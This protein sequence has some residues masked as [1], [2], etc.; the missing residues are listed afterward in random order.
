M[1][2][3]KKL[4]ILFPKFFIF[5]KNPVIASIALSMIFL[6]VF[7]IASLI[8]LN[9]FLN[10]L[11]IGSTTFVLIQEPA[12]FHFSFIVSQALEPASFTLSQFKA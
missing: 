12:A 1:P 3:V 11:A 2:P 6:N 4:P 7:T 10:A 8:I 5:P 9:K